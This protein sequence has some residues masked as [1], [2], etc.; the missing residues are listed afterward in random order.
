MTADEAVKMPAMGTAG[1]R[2]A[3]DGSTALLDE[4]WAQYTPS[5]CWSWADSS[6]RVYARVDATSGAYHQSYL[7]AVIPVLMQ[8][9]ISKKKYWIYNIRTGVGYDW[10]AGGIGAND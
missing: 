2:A 4:G 10:I 6:G 1:V 5:A 9:C 7:T 3:A 8:L